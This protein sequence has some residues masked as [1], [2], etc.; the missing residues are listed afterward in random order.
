MLLAV[1]KKELKRVF[2]D[3]RL[4]ISTFIIPALSIYIIY[5][6][7][8]N[9]VGN[10]VGNINNHSSRILI[11][12]AP[13]S[14]RNYYSK[15]EKDYNFDISFAEHKP[16]S[17]KE[18]IIEGELELITEFD[19]DFDMRL[20]Q[21][22]SKGE[23]P[24][25]KSYG[26][27]SLEYSEKARSIFVYEL[28]ESYEKKVLGDRF[29]NEAFINAFDID[30][31]NSEYDLVNEKKASSMGLG[32][33]LPMLL[34]IILFAGAMGIGMDTIAGEKERGTMANLLITPVPRE[35]I[36]LGKVIGLGTVAIM[37]AA[38]SFGAILLSLPNMVNSFEESAPEMSSMAIS[39]SVLQ[40]LQLFALMISLVG[41]YVGII[42]LISVK[43]RSVKEAGTYMS[44]VYMA[45]MVASFS[46][47][48]TIGAQDNIKVFG[49]PL[50]GNIRA[51]KELFSF[52]LSWGEF[53]IA[54]LVS[55]MTAA[56]LIKLIT[57][58]FNDEKVMLNS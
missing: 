11:V 52:E 44:P 49:I 37:S 15:V 22:K 50:Y 58:A 56:V 29:G 40:Y 57:K 35:T 5:S 4:V 8:G 17:Y 2:S 13:E 47:M 45:I 34:A 23:I 51:I 39:F 53:G 24:Q 3:R 26:N 54:V 20:Q 42:C 32:M 46:T 33:I 48:N 21:Y 28:L 9:M 16:D 7:M 14:F 12:N 30:R 1:I 41:I 43:A 31:E 19:K 27:S 10:K 25:I 6:F 55:L 38:C 36:A 18:Q